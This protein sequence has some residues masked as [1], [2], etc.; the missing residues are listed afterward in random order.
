MY[1]DSTLGYGHQ[2]ARDERRVEVGSLAELAESEHAIDSFMAYLGAG[3]ELGPRPWIIE[4]LANL[5]YTYSKDEGFTE[6]GA[7]AASLVVAERDGGVLLSELGLRLG[8][9]LDLDGPFLSAELSTFWRH[10]FGLKS[11]A[12]TAS[13]VD[14]QDESFDIAGAPSLGDG[15]RVEAGLRF[16]GGDS[17][18][19]AI[20]YGL[21]LRGA[22]SASGLS[23]SL[24]YG[25]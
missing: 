5:C 18:S 25:F 15:V 6:A 19:L 10:D 14:A 17:L 2:I 20:Q 22:Y 13:F 16:G 3:L 21:E 4:P 9:A 8:F 7:G 24:Q 1:F 23:A 11:E 12:I